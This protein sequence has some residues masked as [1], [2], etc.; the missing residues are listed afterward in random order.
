MAQRCQGRWPL[1]MAAVLGGF[2]PPHLS[3]I[4]VPIISVS[5]KSE[6]KKQQAPGSLEESC[7]SPC[8]Q[9][10]GVNNEQQLLPTSWVFGGTQYS[11]ISGLWI[12][13]F[14]NPVAHVGHTQIGLDPNPW[15]FEPRKETKENPGCFAWRESGRS[16]LEGTKPPHRRHSQVYD[17]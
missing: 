4:N 14:P 16:E 17:I 7:H 12:L 2:L 8:F 1:Y 13:G 5:K 6:N 11:S 15:F 3:N 9:E 10:A